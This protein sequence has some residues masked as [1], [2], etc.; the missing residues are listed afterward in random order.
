MK[1]VKSFTSSKKRLFGILALLAAVALLSFGGFTAARYV[2]Q[3]Q[4]DGAATA[5]K[6]YFTSDYLKEGTEN[7]TYFIDP[8]THSFQVAL[9]N[10]ADLQ[11]YASTNIQYTVTETGA[12]VEDSTNGTLN[13]KKG[14]AAQ[15]TITPTVDK[16]EFTVTA[17][18]TAPYQKTLTATFKLALGNQYKVEDAT[19]NTAA[20]LTITCIDDGGQIL[21]SLP[22]GVVPD[23]TD[24]R[25]TPEGNGYKFKAPDSGV[26]SLVL[27]KTDK[28]KNLSCES[29]AFANSI[30][31]SD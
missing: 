4:Q 31:L 28:N 7:A 30:T 15:V 12:K 19:G 9:Y 26:Y 24:G 6:F 17:Q 22:S 21:L 3:Q 20:M 14:S 23:A 10:T 8:K 2:L 25:V 1:H 18:A 27:L 13:G 11:R 16:G 29:K 5:Q